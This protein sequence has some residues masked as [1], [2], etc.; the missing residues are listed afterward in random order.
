MP[1]LYCMLV[2][3]AESVEPMMVFAAVM[4]CFGSNPPPIGITHMER[5]A[6]KRWRY[7]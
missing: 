1:P 6:K 3:S 5:Y 7:G 2:D 4:V